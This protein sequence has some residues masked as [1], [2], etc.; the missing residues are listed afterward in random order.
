MHR[1]CQTRQDLWS[2]YQLYLPRGEMELYSSDECKIKMKSFT[3]LEQINI[4][5]IFVY[6]RPCC[7]RLACWQCVRTGISSWPKTS[8]K[9]TR[10]SSK[11]TS[12]SMSS[13]SRKRMLLEAEILN[14]MP[15]HTF[16]LSIYVCV[17]IYSVSYEHLWSP[18][19]ALILGLNSPHCNTRPN[20][21]SDP[22]ANGTHTAL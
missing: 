9:L 18:T 15:R 8:K 5:L 11:R 19:L 12:R 20:D 16:L 13:T 2:R 21:R 3:L 6:F 4:Y 22:S 1:C 7:L 10:L 14:K 17:T